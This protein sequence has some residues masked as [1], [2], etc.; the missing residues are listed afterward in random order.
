MDYGETLL[1][2]HRETGGYRNVTY[3]DFLRVETISE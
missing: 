1:L 3:E 2:G